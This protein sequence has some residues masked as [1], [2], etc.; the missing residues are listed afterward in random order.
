MK[1]RILAYVEQIDN[2]LK[3]APNN[4]DWNEIIRRH[5]I[6]IQL[7]QHE[8]LIHLIVTALFAVM[9]TGCILALVISFHL[10]LVVLLLPLLILLSPYISH[11]YLL[12]NNVQKMYQQYDQMIEFQHRTDLR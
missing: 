11:Y 8:R 5:L 2:L 4:S 6:Q 9:T 10:S 3:E 7:F 1:K 12:E